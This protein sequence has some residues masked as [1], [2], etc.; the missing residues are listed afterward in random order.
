MKKIIILNMIISLCFSLPFMP[1]ATAAEPNMADYTAYPIFMVQAVQPS[2][3]IILDNSGSMNFNAYGSWPGNGGEITNALFA[4]EPYHQITRT[5]ERNISATQDDAEENIAP[6]DNVWSNHDLDLGGFNDGSDDSVV[7]LR[8]QNIPI[9]KGA[10]IISA[11][12]EFEAYENSTTLPADTSFIFVG[13]NSDDAAQFENTVDNVSSRP[14]TAAS[15]VWNSVP[16]WTTD[17][18]YQTPELI[19]I[20]QE[21]INREQWREGNALAFRITGNGRRD[22][23][24]FDH[25]V[26]GHSPLLHI[27]FQ[28][29][30]KKI[31]YGYFNPDYFYYYNSG[32][33]VH[34]YKKIDYTG[35]SWSAQDLSG[36]SVTLADTDIV[37]E[38]LWDGNWLNWVSMRR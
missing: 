31:Y 23:K 32:T 15:V 13:E 6:G 28:L 29:P 4:G 33:F 25:A 30:E 11:Y 14:A 35:G 12:I 27:E 2:I 37:S 3:M 8:F 21:I 38:E 16:D 1:S 34:K 17:N 7:G 18:L 36:T 9:P 19:A 22:A 5:E 10:T 20:V 26:A 24:S